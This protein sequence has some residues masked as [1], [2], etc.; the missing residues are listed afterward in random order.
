MIDLLERL[1]SSGVQLR[2]D[3]AQLQV[4]AP[5]GAMTPELR[6][7]LATH[8]QALH[9]W[10]SGRADDE[11][12]PPFT[13]RPDLRH[14]PFALTDIQHAYWMGRQAQ[15]ELG[16]FST[17]FYIELER[18]GL[19]LERLEAGLQKVIARHD[20]LRAVVDD[21]GLQRVLPEVLPYRIDALDLREADAAAQQAAIDLL[22]Q[23]LSH[24]RLPADRWPLFEIR[25]V[26]LPGNRLRLF[27]SLDMLIVDASSMLMFFEEWRSACEDEAWSPPPLRISFR[28]Y[29]EFERRLQD[30]PVVR[31]ARDYWTARLD[32]LPAPPELPLAVQPR[33]LSRV[34]FRRRVASVPAA[35]WQRLKDRAQQFGATPSALL[36]TA[37]SETLRT[38]SKSPDF[39]LNLTLFNRVPAHPEV[40]SLLGDFTTTSLLAVHARRGDSF[41]DRLQRLQRQLA[42]DLEHRH[43]SGVRVL[44]DRARRLG[45]A[46][47]AAMPVVFTSLLALASQQRSASGLAYFGSYEFG[48]SQTPQVWL[49]HQVTEWEGDLLL[50]WD[51]AE[52]LFPAGLLDD[53]FGAYVALI[54]RL[55]QDESAWTARDPWPILPD[56]Q[57]RLFA[58]ANATAVE[59]PAAMLHAGAA[60]QASCRP[61]APAVISAAG[62]LTHGELQAH[63]CRLGRQ[64]RATAAAGS[65]V[66]I[67][68]DKGWEQ[69][70][71]LF[72]V[73]H[74]ACAYL[75]IDASLP[76]QRRR[77]LMELAQVR[78]VVTQPAL[79]DSLEWP[80][81]IRLLTLADA[82]VSGQ[83]GSPLPIQDAPHALAYVLFTSGST[84]DPK[85]VMIEH[86]QAVNTLQD[87]N[88]RFEVGPSDRVLGLSAAH[89]DLSVYDVF[90]VLA[91]GGAVV[92][93]S[94]GQATDA[95]HWTDL[96]RRHG[97]TL[98]NSVP[99]LLELWTDH[100]LALE[101]TC[102]TVRRVIV[103]GDWV[104]LR[105]PDRV[106]RC[107]PAA[108]FLA[109]GGATEVS[110]WSTQYAVG[111]VQADWK[112]IPYGKPL[113]NQTMHVFNSLLEPRAV[114]VP[115]EIC[116]GG[117]GVGRGYL[118]DAEKTAQRFVVHPDTGE[119]LY[120]S[121]DLGRYL[122]DGNIE[123]L[124]REDLQVKVNGHR[125][126]LGE[127]EAAIRRQGLTA[128]VLVAVVTSAES[129]QK[130]LAAY[131][132]PLHAPLDADALRQAL[133]D[134][135]PAHMVPALWMQLDRLPLT[136][137]GKVDRASLPIPGSQARSCI[138]QLAPRN[139]IERRLHALWSSLLGH[140]QFGMD[141]NV[142]ALGLDSISMIRLAARMKLE[143]G[144]GLPQAMVLQRLLAQ[145][146]VAQL[147]VAVT[148]WTAA[149]E[150]PPPPPPPAQPDPAQRVGADDALEQPF[151]ATDLQLGY[152]CGEGS[153][154]QY[155]VRSNYFIDF[156]LD[157]AFDALRLEAALNRALERQKD[158]LVVLREDAQLQVVRPW[159][160]VRLQAVHDLR[161]RDAAA[162]EQS[163]DEIRSA[164]ERRVL[165]LDRW[166][167][168][169]FRACLLD[170]E[171]RLLV[172][173]VNHFMDVV[174]FRRLLED[175]QCCHAQPDCSLP[176]LTLTY[177]DCVLA[178]RQLEDSASGRS[179]E[180]YWRDR[181]AHLPPPPPVPLLSTVDPA[182][183]SRLVRRDATIPAS[184]W[185]AFRRTAARHGV[186]ATTAL[187]GAYAEVLAA[188]SGTRHFLLGHMTSFRHH[189][190]HPQA[191]QI[192]GGFNT[193]Y[194]M[195]I[196]FRQPLPFH[197]R[198]RGLQV[199]MLLDG[200]HQHWGGG[201]VWQALNQARRSP[202]MAPAPFVV[203]SGLDLPAWEQPFHGCLE[204]PQVLFDHQ[205]WNLADGRL[206]LL[207]DVNE[208]HFPPG[209]VDAFW[210]AYQ[211]LIERLCT[212]DTAW[213][214]H[215]FD[216]LPPQQREVRAAANRTAIARPPGL[217]QDLLRHAARDMPHQPAVIA[218]GRTVSYR[219]LEDHA[220]RLA[221]RLRE[222]GVGR[223]DP[224]VIA[225]ER[226]CGQAVAVHGVLGA[227]GA[228]VPIDLDWPPE[229][230]AF[231][232]ADTGA[233]C[234]VSSLAARA[235]L[236]LPSHVAC[237]CVDD[238]AL[239]HHPSTAPA[240]LQ[241]PGDLAYVIYTSGSTGRPKGVMID[242]RAALN[243]VLDI[244]ERIGLSRSD[245]VFG[246]SA[247]TFDLSVY[248][249]F[250]TAAAGATLLLPTTAAP[251]PA[252]W[253]HAM[254]RH[255]VTVWNSVP[256]LMHLLTD[257]ADLE[258]QQLSTLATVMLSGD[259]I[260][261][262]LPE[263]VRRVAPQAAIHSLG[264]ATEAAIWSITHRIDQVDGDWTSIP[265]GRPLGNQ[266]WHVLAED[267]SDAPDWV[268]GQLHIGGMGLAL[269]YWRDEQ[270][271]AAS[272]VTH[273]R[274]GERLYR[275]GDLGRYRPDGT[276]EFLG[277]N[278]H[279]VKVQGHRIE[280]GE[281]EHALL[282]HPGVQAAAVVAQGDRKAKRLVAFVVAAEGHAV[283]G[284][285]LR[286]H[287]GSK[288][289]GHMVPQQFACLPQLPLSSNGK[290]DRAALTEGATCPAPARHQEFGSP[291]TAL[292]SSLVRIW[293]SVLEVSPIGIHDDF[294]GLG[295][296]SLAAIQVMT[297]IAQ[298][299]GVHLPLGELLRG[300]TV[301]HLAR[302]IEQ[303]ARWSPLVRINS[304]EAGTPLFLVHPAGGHVLCYQELAQR[305]Q[306]P[307]LGLQAPGLEGDREP[308]EDINA[309]AAL[310]V[311]ALREAQPA[312]PYHLGGWSSGGLVAFE[313]ARQ[314]EDQGDTVAQL[315]LID[316]PS[317]RPVAAVDD[318]TLLCWF[319]HD[320]NPGLRNAAHV[321]AATADASVAQALPLINGQR[322]ETG[323]LT[324]DQIEPIWRVFRA[325]VRAGC[326]YR[327]GKLQST[328]VV[329]KASRMRVAEFADHPDQHAPDWGW[330]PFTHGGVR[331][332]KVPGDHHTMWHGGG[333]ALLS[334]LL[335]QP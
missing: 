65:I 178:Y 144:L 44:R 115:G 36:L 28:D 74:G 265:Y 122:P 300:R 309:M 266:S 89:F 59:L 109:A 198:L 200:Q 8:R 99:Q 247:I 139:D 128:D 53:M 301:E 147:A 96:V 22:R 155:P 55:G 113:A 101:E 102:E 313:M 54:G 60:A 32:T 190:S 31:R 238:V 6:D 56:W 120:K 167:W 127:V 80:Q 305:L 316:T 294:F 206:W 311:R 68:M 94:P 40:A 129:G 143:F 145:P 66:G 124:G 135:L 193:V 172:N 310:Y 75:P 151:P 267:G 330:S 232:L 199:Q 214:R 295:G 183:P 245:V 156:C 152:L 327:A 71:A 215:T 334:A 325:M 73:L 175:L 3:G 324:L 153:G 5:K 125:I 271:T 258:G 18:A 90:G 274:S 64:L 63:A 4:R 296:H 107:C 282:S 29:V 43:Y 197:E 138:T 150:G 130:Q 195:E 279:Q 91:T 233:R 284:S 149:G 230:I 228:Y 27:V 182:S 104:P 69:V 86:G 159:S 276:I 126:E 256:A 277:R 273:P 335:M 185:A 290:V 219:E 322:R 162:V 132:V 106:R 243:T 158:N 171:T 38:W 11:A 286:E 312:G 108:S 114:W 133:A 264:G 226:G 291:R 14:Q 105:Q 179:S 331:H 176:P 255:G 268:P 224:V 24:N 210:Q 50:S 205:F 204:T 83:D 192:A 110:I 189:V 137:N 240:A 15:V 217:L 186:S 77:R 180:R 187:Q 211:A 1:Q 13:P 177:R 218:A 239:H 142:L 285:R 76:F 332:V 25:A 169:E 103:S 283:D 223:A 160:P 49:D 42:Q 278:D 47:G 275:T 250:G 321:S 116:F 333:L 306:R 26:C 314:L 140:G 173:T 157:A 7:L 246:V 34:E 261:L 33:T 251:Q 289:P 121:G 281:I 280:L 79:R 37:F 16:G 260:P 163:L 216:L 12:L 148:E 62:M 85:G 221:H 196:D 297:R 88:R 235:R 67:C 201:R 48:A 112:S 165:P 231:V 181:I 293:E 92:L 269:G 317:P 98:W 236:Q 57:R 58:A 84:G 17:H 329:A 248:D 252:E 241:H 168:I 253:L 154:M 72:G 39:T 318:A 131:V 323:R 319:V 23:R 202:G 123:F 97:V 244:N 272:F 320:M 20:M 237:V 111:E 249:L 170:R 2:L 208:Q 174:T 242:H 302:S 270:R 184:H 118:N 93:P 134:S 213:A 259:W 166:P 35:T 308:I 328:I 212:D 287:L 292:Q 95:A 100:L 254:Q 220:N 51:A 326:A 117:T 82:D 303:A 161:G 304:I 19:G 191:Q 146:T 227:G 164:L 207:I 229:R 203:A 10:L 209:L 222:A 257:A 41:A 70:A 299:H 298:R 141:D 307:V 225:V 119:R 78:T 87:I 30:Q 288:L 136:P 81:G 262:T 46:P 61:D 188:W 194:P 263:Q 234:V 45:Q 21:D 52:A 315:T 9:D